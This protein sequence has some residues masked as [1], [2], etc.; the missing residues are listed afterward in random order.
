MDTKDTHSSILAQL[1]KE[2]LVQELERRR[3]AEMPET[4]LEA[5]QA[6][7]AQYD[8][9][10][11]AAFATYLL[12]LSAKEGGGKKHCPKCG[13]LCRI[14]AHG[15]PRLI[16]TTTGLH[17]LKR[18]QYYCEG[19]HESFYPLDEQLGL[20][21]DGEA[22][23]DLE[24]RVLDFGVTTT[25]KEAE[26]R[27][28]VHYNQAIS[29]NLIR[30]IVESSQ[31]IMTCARIRDVQDVIR[32]VPQAP[33]KM[34]VIQTDG[35]MVPTRGE[36]PWKETKLGVIYRD[37]NRVASTETQRGCVT[38]ARY[39]G[40]LGTVDVFKE[41]IRE[42]LNI[43]RAGEAEEVA[44]LGDGAAWNWSMANELCPTAVQ[45]LDPMHALQHASDCGKVL[46]NDDQIMLRLWNE[47]IKSILYEDKPTTLLME[48]RGCWV[49]A[50][51]RQ[52]EALD[53]LLG[54]YGNNKERM[55]YQLYRSK[56]LPIG[57]GAVESAHK[58]VI[59]KR[60]KLAGQ[61]WDIGRGRGMVEL[62]TAYR[63]TGPKK[64]HSVIGQLKQRIREFG[65]RAA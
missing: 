34:L 48:L 55:N 7:T 38:E 4:M 13:Q 59:Q 25:F 56:G 35:G 33:A 49:Q 29:E 3:S 64:L 28:S 30:R 32:E 52:R 47:R 36:E 40:H 60:M 27:W 50:T 43:E 31:R 22:S 15:R 23:P 37:N 63:T 9:E 6:L 45:I 11:D 65:K 17:T 1:T 8:E 21:E 42:A 2:E 44:W 14:R 39:V 18:N 26:E 53:K 19:C 57:S 5:E 51:P 62:R 41:H 10:R 46:F 24:R 16:R 61:H 20:S 54:Y 58:H 12:R